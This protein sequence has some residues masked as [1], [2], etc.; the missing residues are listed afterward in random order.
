MLANSYTLKRRR[1]HRDEIA[2]L[3]L[4]GSVDACDAGITGLEE[5][6]DNKSGDNCE[7]AKADWTE[8]GAKDKFTLTRLLR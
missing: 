1:H 4:E 6:V 3:D 2:I 5:D 7:L 8:F